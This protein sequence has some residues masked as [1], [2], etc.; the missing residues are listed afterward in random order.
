LEVIGH[1]AVT[2]VDGAHVKT[3]AYR[4][5]GH[6]PLM[7]SGA[8]LHSLPAG[9]GYDVRARRLLTEAGAALQ[10]ATRERPSDQQEASE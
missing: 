6:K 2:V 4:G 10:D 3:D 7:V 9:Y 1:G 5:K 8:V